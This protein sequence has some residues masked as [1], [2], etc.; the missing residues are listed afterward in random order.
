MSRYTKYAYNLQEL[1]ARTVGVQATVPIATF[2]F[3]IFSE[4]QRLK[5]ECGTTGD[6]TVLLEHFENSK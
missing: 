5:T 4:L 6:E 3:I 1:E 2:L